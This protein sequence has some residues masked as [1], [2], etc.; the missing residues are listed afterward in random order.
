MILHSAGTHDFTLYRMTLK[1]SQ[2]WLHTILCGLECERCQGS[3]SIKSSSTGCRE[4]DDA[5]SI[6]DAF[7]DYVEN[8][9]ANES[10]SECEDEVLLHAG[11]AARSFIAYK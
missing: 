2:C 6:D 4:M 9:D 1:P 7:A 8:L 5:A 10:D 3:V 11:S